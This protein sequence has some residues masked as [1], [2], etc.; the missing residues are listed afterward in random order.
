MT[1]QVYRGYESDPKNSDQ[2][3]AEDH[4]LTYRGSKHEPKDKQ[5]E[6]RRDDERLYY[7]GSAA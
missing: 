5:K 3:K 4:E 6:E 2:H 7:R 1:K